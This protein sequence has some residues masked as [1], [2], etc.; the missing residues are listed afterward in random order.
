[1]IE[2]LGYIDFMS[3]VKNSAYV[4][5]DSGGVQEET[6]YLGVPCFTLRDSTER[7]VTVTI[8]SNQLVTIQNL[9]EKIER[10]KKGTIPPLWDG[11]T[12]LRIRDMLRHD[13][14]IT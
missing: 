6:T 12:A 3:L 7:P 10:P 13:K 5:S 9:L 11:Q 1:M 14:L 8:G 4:I 2:P